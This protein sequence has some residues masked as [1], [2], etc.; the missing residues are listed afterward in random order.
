MFERVAVV[1]AGTMG[2]GIAQV[3][4]AAG[5]DVVVIDREREALDRGRNALS[6]SLA[7][8]VKRSRMTEADAGTVAARVAWQPDIGAARGCGLVIEAIVER[9]EVKRG[10][11]ADLSMLVSAETVLASNT[12]SLS[13]AAMA[14]GL[15]YPERFVGLHFF[16]PVPAMKLV[17]VVAGPATDPA[18]V[19]R[20][21]VLM[22]NW[23]KHAVA[24]RDVPGFI[25][26]RVARPYYA[27]AFLALE[28]GIEPAAIDT[29]LTAGGGFRMGPLTLADL[30]GHDINYAAASSVFE[31]MQPHT[32]FRPQPGQARL[33]EQGLLGRK[34]GRGVYDYSSEPRPVPPVTGRLA[35]EINIAP[36]ARAFSWLLQSTKCL[37]NGELPAESISVDGIVMA[38]GD[39]RPLSRRSDVDALLDHVADPASSPIL[40]VTVRDA[41]AAEAA[42]RLASTLG[43]RL[44]L[45]PDRPGQIVLRTLAQLANGAADAV[46]DGVAPA[47]SIDEAMIYGANYPQ[48]PIAWARAFGP[49]EV[50]RALSNIAAATGDALY[51]PSTGLDRL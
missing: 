3:A 23:G 8:L 21:A 48:G 38:Y 49:A 9:L 22:R 19:E 37:H 27:E 12:S 35:E 34:A 40:I 5:H 13:I 14:D 7:S 1:G 43:K 46:E 10:L 36:D 42:G 15:A 26:N 45:V 32:R 47:P 20:M 25:V 17:E 30:I 50:A 29:A 51:A 41:R 24:V 16:N 11:F 39:G 28:D 33:V 6:D 31:G 4:A 18:L 44:V 2:S